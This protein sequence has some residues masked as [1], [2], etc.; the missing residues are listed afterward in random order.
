MLEVE[1]S[2]SNQNF[3]DMEK[4]LVILKPSCVKRNLIGEVTSRFEKKGLRL[5]GM[6]MIQLTDDILDVHYAHL[7][8]KPF[9]GEIKR[10][11]KD[12]PVVVQCWVGLEAVTV[13]RKLTGFTNGREANPGT[14]RGDYSISFQENIIHASDSLETAKV[15]LDRFFDP[16]EI[17][18]ICETIFKDLYSKEELL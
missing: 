13:V 9:F 15:E 2:H 6:K 3:I 10:S 12:S 18:N 14:I 11:M 16:S 1:C 7:K 17:F 5:A 8:D 4:T